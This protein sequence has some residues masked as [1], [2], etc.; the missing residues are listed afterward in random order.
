MGEN[1]N[2]SRNSGSKRF[3]APSYGER[4]SGGGGG[5]SSS[6]SN[7]HNSG[8]PAIKSFAASQMSNSVPSW[9]SK[10]SESSNNHWPSQDRYDRTYNE[11]SGPYMDAPPRQSGMFVGSGGGGRPQDRYGGQISRYDSGKY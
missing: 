4:S 2:Y 7:W 8:P 11:R 5:G 6:S 1:S 3:D 9:Q 10:S